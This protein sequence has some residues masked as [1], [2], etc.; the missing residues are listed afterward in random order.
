MGWQEIY[1]KQNPQNGISHEK[2][3]QLKL[4]IRTIK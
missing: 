3:K 2:H 1:S 4:K